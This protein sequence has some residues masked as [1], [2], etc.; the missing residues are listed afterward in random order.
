MALCAVPGVCWHDQRFPEASS[1]QAQAKP[2]VQG[3]ALKISATRPLPR[4]ACGSPKAPG[5]EGPNCGGTEEES[6]AVTAADGGA[7][8]LEEE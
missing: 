7:R 3:R 6:G 4:A 8:V 5:Q 2:D 1:R